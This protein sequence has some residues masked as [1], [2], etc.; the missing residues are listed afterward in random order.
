M[1]RIINPTSAAILGLL[2]Q[3]PMTGS[4]IKIMAE[5]WLLPFWNM[6]HSQIYRE[7]PTLAE[8]GLVKAGKTGPRLALP[9]KITSAGKKAFQKWLREDSSPD[10]LRSE[11]ALRVALGG[12]QEPE[13][14]EQLMAELIDR[15]STTI[16]QIGELIEEAETEGMSYDAEALRFA[17][18]YHHMCV[19]WLSS[20]ELP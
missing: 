4:E 1:N 16:K 17:L 13:Q 15:H 18:S 10:L 5:K 8:R 6:T 12:L 2:H 3:A 14:V 11:A 20:V 9:Y 19:E 7:L